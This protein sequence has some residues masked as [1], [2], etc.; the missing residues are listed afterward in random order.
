LLRV[1]LGAIFVMHGYDALAVLGAPAAAA[2]VVRLGY[3]A[4]LALPLAWYLIVAHGAGGALLIVGLWTRWA[5]LVQVPIMASA[6][7]L[8]HLPQGFFMRGIVEDRAAGRAIAGGYEYSLLV[9]AATLAVGL[10]GAGAW[11]V[12]R[13][14]TNPRRP[15]LP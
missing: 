2:L 11:S 14:R 13:A 5:A 12:D 15:R 3:P 10:S 6:V 7:F 9:L 4:A 8:L 1:A